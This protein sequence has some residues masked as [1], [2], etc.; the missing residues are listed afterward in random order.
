VLVEVTFTPSMTR[1]VAAPVALN[2][3]LLE[4]QSGLLGRVV[5]V[6]KPTVKVESSV[7]SK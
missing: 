7:I 2:V 5:V 6:A 1:V 4:D 3:L